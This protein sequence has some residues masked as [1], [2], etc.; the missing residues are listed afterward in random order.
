MKVTGN[1]KPPSNLAAEAVALK[2]AVL[3]KLY[4]KIVGTA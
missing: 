2:G 4:Q 1:K 3:D